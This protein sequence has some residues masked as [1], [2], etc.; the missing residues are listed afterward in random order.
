[1]RG[2]SVLGKNPKRIPTKLSSSKEYHLRIQGGAIVV[3]ADFYP[4]FHRDDCT[5]CLFYVSGTDQKEFPAL[6]GRVAPA[7]P[8]HHEAIRKSRSAESVHA[9]NPA[10]RLTGGI[11]SRKG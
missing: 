7:H 1:M 2:D 4:F 3:E 10:Y 9:E 5:G 11:E 8:S 6:H